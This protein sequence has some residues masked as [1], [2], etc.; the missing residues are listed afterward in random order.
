MLNFLVLVLVLI[1]ILVLVLILVQ[2]A[3]QSSCYA[4][5]HADMFSSDI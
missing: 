3:G 4:T 5:F 1:L 2:G